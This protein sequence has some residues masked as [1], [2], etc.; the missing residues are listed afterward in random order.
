MEDIQN[1]E[2][3]SQLLQSPA[4]LHT[5]FE[6]NPVHGVHTVSLLEEQAN[7]AR[8]PRPQDVHGEHLASLD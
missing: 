1:P 7:A 2:T 3:Q 8:N 6:G 4:V 5:E